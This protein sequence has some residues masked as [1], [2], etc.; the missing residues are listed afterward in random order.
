MNNKRRLK[1]IKLQ[2]LYKTYITGD[3][4]QKAL[5]NVSLNLRDNEFV[6][7]L[8]PSGSGKTTLL[9]IIGGLDRYD[10]GDI[11]INNVS[12]KEYTDRQW[13]TYRNH[14]IGFV[15]QSYNLIP[16]QTLLSN[17]E[18]ALTIGGVSRAERKRRALEALEDVGLREQANKKPNQLSGGQ[19]QRVAIARA[20]VN[21]PDIVLADEPT[22]ALDSVTSIQVMDLLKK[23][24]EKRLVVMVT[25]NAELAEE[26]ATR[27]VSLKDGQ[28]VGDTKPYRPRSTKVKSSAKSGK[29]KMNFRTAL[30]LSFN[31][32]L[33]KKG[34]T[35]L[36]SFAGSIG[37]IG[38][39]LILSL[40][41]GFKNYIDHIQ[42]DTLTS[43]PLTITKETADLSEIFLSMSD[44]SSTSNKKGKVKKGYI[45]EQKHV[46]SLANS[47][48]IND[49]KSL[50][51]KLANDSTEL[52][53]M[54]SR[55]D[56]GYSVEPLIYKIDP[57]NTINRINPAQSMTSMY[58]SSASMMGMDMGGT[59]YEVPDDV[60]ILKSNYNI[61]SGRLP[62]RYNE[63]LLTLQDKNEIS[64][65][66]VYSLG[67]RDTKELTSIMKDIMA[68]KKP[69]IK[70]KAKE[71]KYED[72]LKITFKLVNPNDLYKYNPEYNIYEDMNSD[73]NYM[74][75]VYNKSEDIKIVGIATAKSKRSMTNRSGIAYTTK[76]VNHVVKT[77]SKTDIVK[78]Q[79][80]NKKIDVFSN[81]SFDDQTQENGNIK[82]DNMITVDQNALASAFSGDGSGMDFS[83]DPSETQEIVESVAEE[84]ANKIMN[85]MNPDDL[86]KA[87]VNI[88]NL[89]LST[90]VS[91]YE[92]AN[93][94]GANLS[95]ANVDTAMSQITVDKYKEIVSLAIGSSGGEGAML[96]NLLGDEDYNTLTSVTQ[97]MFKMYYD[98]LRDPSL[99]YDS[100]NQLIAIAKDSN[101]TTYGSV[102]TITNA[103]LILRVNI[104]PITT[105]PLTN[106][107]NN[108]VRNYASVMVAVG[109]GD[110]TAQVMDPIS[111]KLASL[112]SSFG[113]DP[114]AIA[115]AFKFNMT[116]EDIQRLVQAMMSDTGKKSYETNLS[117]LGYQDLDDP[118]SI[119]F[120][121]KD[122]DSKEEFIKYL[123]NYNKK[124]KVKSKKIEYTDTTGLLMS[125]VQTIVDAVS[126]VLIAFVSVSLIVSSIMIAVITLI[127]VMERK[128]E[129]GILRA[130][131]ASKNN[132]SSIFNAETF[133]IGL[134]SGLV[135]VGVSLLL[136]FPI[137]AIIHMAM[138]NT[139]VTAVLKFSYGLILVLIAVGL[140]MIAGFAP[141]KK[142]SKNDPV[143]SLRA[144]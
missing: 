140:N 71:F 68:G 33:T 32:L 79:L 48:G 6:A 65:Y 101:E 135:G 61:V 121:F 20:L 75:D 125:S 73:E 118:S 85:D 80:A 14:T 93:T 83:S 86:T 57:T 24:A 136:L 126:Y 141:S 143:E 10:D 88:N 84:Y 132:V 45:K 8:G 69:N 110:G 46:T 103:A 18:L 60:K 47:I 107:V 131:G 72:M 122:F 82:F 76:L 99:G 21:N 92:D 7:I 22:G 15:F 16:H 144:E 3:L 105:M 28:I 29:A 111:K 27:I 97:N 116:Q 36:T 89:V 77:A 41:Q 1:M 56:Y 134:L 115:N 109:I 43:Y 130:M 94:S 12:T 112:S 127:S 49:L 54:V 142:A 44:D 5:D 35:I 78:K 104:N 139:E 114:K 128:K 117:E 4:T 26:Y 23:V 129:I 13:D 66:L 67:L 113:V 2:N 70:I 11:I 87:L 123:D 102:N 106:V 53:E 40:S 38:I 55:I 39:A 25:H 62:S 74:K 96:V 50:K 52:D 9:N 37:I 19:M 58:T 120:Y 91:N 124:V 81:K 138:G 30:S 108:M 59:F 17:V 137:N 119:S 98:N 34:R 100:S 95:L 42:E 51:K 31:N 90:T 133:I 63:V 64:D